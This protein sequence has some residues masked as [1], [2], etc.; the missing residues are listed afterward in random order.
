MYGS[1]PALQGPCLIVQNVHSQQGKGSDTASPAHAW[2]AS[3]GSTRG[4]VMWRRF[5]FLTRSNVVPPAATALCILIVARVEVIG[6]LI[7]LSMVAAAGAACDALRQYHSCTVSGAVWLHLR[8]ASCTSVRDSSTQYRDGYFA[9]FLRGRVVRLGSSG[10]ERIGVVR[11]S[12]RASSFLQY[13]LGE[14]RS[15]YR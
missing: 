8:R 6:L 12:A 7:Q 14:A 9:Q 2:Q 13:Q 1:V 11:L 5:G 4:T 3:R 10:L 15:Y